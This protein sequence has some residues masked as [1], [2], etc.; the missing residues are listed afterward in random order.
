MQPAHGAH[1]RD[2]TWDQ[3]LHI[4]LTSADQ[5]ITAMAPGMRAR[6]GYCCPYNLGVRHADAGPVMAD[7]TAK[8]GLMH[9]THALAKD[10]APYVRVNAVAP[11]HLDPARTM[12]AGAGCIACVVQATP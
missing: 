8:A 1:M 4:N 11:G 9:L 12:A 2:D 7:T 3:T 6:A 10:L 5:L